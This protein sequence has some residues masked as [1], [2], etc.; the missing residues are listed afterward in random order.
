MTNHQA[1]SSVVYRLSDPSGVTTSDPEP[2]AVDSLANGA[3]SGA[4]LE[5]DYALQL[6]VLRRG[7]ELLLKSDV[8][9]SWRGASDIGSVLVGHYAAF[10]A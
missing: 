6:F 10:F 1:S 4:S 9:Y 2:G 5:A 3:I 7:K 8:G